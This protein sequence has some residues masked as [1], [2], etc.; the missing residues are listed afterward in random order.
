ML[1]VDTLRLTRKKNT[2]K[3]GQGGLE[4]CFHAIPEKSNLAPTW[5]S[6]ALVRYAYT[7]PPLTKFLPAVTF[8][9]QMR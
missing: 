6:N 7:T 2:M 5:L 1:P 9:F 4:V 8:I 3:E